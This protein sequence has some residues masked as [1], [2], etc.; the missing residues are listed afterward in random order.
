[1]SAPQ[2]PTFPPYS[3]CLSLIKNQ[4]TTKAVRPEHRIANIQPVS[5][6]AITGVTCAKKLMAEFM[7]N[8][9]T[10]SKATPRG[11]VPHPSRC[12]SANSHPCSPVSGHTRKSPLERAGIPTLLASTRARI[13]C[14]PGSD[15]TGGRQADT[16]SDRMFAKVFGLPNPQATDKGAVAYGT[17]N[18]AC[19]HRSAHRGHH[20]ARH[21]HP[22]PQVNLGGFETGLGQVNRKGR[23]SIS[24]AP[25]RF[26]KQVKK[27]LSAR[28]QETRVPACGGLTRPRS[29]PLKTS[30]T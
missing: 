16:T 24:A 9:C 14:S 4:V 12:R 19:E 1:M 23:A 13:G 17:G 26:G 2:L 21:S 28:P 3:Q 27:N 30:G 6:Y 10:N 15:R 7:C 29:R 22:H 5:H 11:D 8:D 20:R 25:K 18:I